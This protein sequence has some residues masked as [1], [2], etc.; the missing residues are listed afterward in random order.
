[1]ITF[2]PYSILF[3]SFGIVIPTLML[4]FSYGNFAFKIGEFSI[5]KKDEH[6]LPMIL[7]MI[8]S[9]LF[10]ISFV[11][12]F[13]YHYIFDN[14]IGHTL[15]TYKII[16][17]GLLITIDGYLLNNELFLACKNFNE[18]TDYKKYIFESYNLFHCKYRLL[19]C[20]KNSM[21][22]GLIILFVLSI[23]NNHLSFTAILLATYIYYQYRIDK[24][25]KSLASYDSNINNNNSTN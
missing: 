9:K 4:L 11:M 12:F 23:L 1:M 7:I 2:E 25:I 15:V 24:Y 14:T 20:I 17:W 19:F 18:I 21:I 22:V 10:I 3:Y 13:I 16:L 5:G 8:M 6:S